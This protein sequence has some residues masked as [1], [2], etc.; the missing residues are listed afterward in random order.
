[1]FEGLKEKK[2][3]VES[4]E[5]LVYL[6]REKPA[7]SVLYCGAIPLAL[8]W[9][10]R[11]SLANAFALQ[12][13]LL[14]AGTFGYEPFRNNKRFVKKWWFW[15]AM[16]GGGVLVHPLFLAGMWYLD[17]ENSSFVRSAAT[18]MLLVFV[19]GV[20]ESIILGSIVNRFRPAEQG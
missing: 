14:T 17:V 1:M 5:A 16:L 12:V 8:L 10:H 2:S 11:E 6:V 18:L 3:M 9:I 20:L 7:R 13:Y 19:A 4:F 15:K